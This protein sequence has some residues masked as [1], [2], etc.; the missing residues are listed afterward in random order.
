MKQL[1]LT[2]ICLETDSPA[3]GPEKQTRNEPCNLRVSA[4]Y[5]AQVK[6]IP[7]DEVVEVTTQNALRLFPRLQHLGT[8]SFSSP[9][10]FGKA[11]AWI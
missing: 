10:A 11:D 5:I 2:S 4:E 7:V 9:V 3:L 6:G 8:N 1:P